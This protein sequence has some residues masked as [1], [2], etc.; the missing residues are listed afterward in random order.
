MIAIK[1]EI[2]ME[3]LKLEPCVRPGH[4]EAIKIMMG[5][6]TRTTNRVNH[7][8]LGATSP[9]EMWHATPPQRQDD[10]F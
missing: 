3:A 1:I 4:V 7:H 8:R 2:M 10:L 9:R 5:G 6:V